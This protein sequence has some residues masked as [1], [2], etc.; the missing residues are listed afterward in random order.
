MTGLEEATYVL[1][2]FFG[3][4]DFSKGVLQAIGYKEFFEFYQR[5]P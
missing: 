1:D 2:Q 5:A 3:Q 4:Y